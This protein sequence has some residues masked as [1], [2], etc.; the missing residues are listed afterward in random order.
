MQPA[1]G[2]RRT[3]LN[4]GLAD[5]VAGMPG[6]CRSGNGLWGGVAFR[7]AEQSMSASSSRLRVGFG[8]RRR[9]EGMRYVR[10]P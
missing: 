4:A 2:C 7:R 3:G 10:K 9:A 8:R 1:P 5:E 6:T